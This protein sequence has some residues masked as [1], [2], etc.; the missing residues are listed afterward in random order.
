[1]KVCTSTFITVGVTDCMSKR[2]THKKKTRFCRKQLLANVSL[3]FYIYWN[4]DFHYDCMKSCRRH[5]QAIWAHPGSSVAKRCAELISIH[6]HKLLLLAGIQQLLGLK[7]NCISAARL[8]NA[9][10]QSEN[11]IC[12][13]HAWVT[14]DQLELCLHLTLSLYDANKAT[15]CT[16]LNSAIDIYIYESKL[17]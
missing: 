5:F 6:Q 13:I 14:G 15:R 3:Q 8:V 17:F 16:R 7:A 11:L 10:A 9:P 2:R 4:Y 1:M 12:L